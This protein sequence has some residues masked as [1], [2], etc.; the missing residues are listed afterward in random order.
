MD[1]QKTIRAWRTIM[2][3][4]VQNGYDFLYQ[5]EIDEVAKALREYLG[6]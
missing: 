5:D 3:I 6:I 4:L 1:K 2:Q